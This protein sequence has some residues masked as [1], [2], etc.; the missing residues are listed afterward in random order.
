MADYAWLITRDHISIPGDDY[1]ATGTSGPRSITDE[2]LARLQAGE[3]K[4]F[5]LFDDDRILIYDGRIINEGNDEN[6]FAPLDDFGG[7]NEGCTII[8]YRDGHKWEVL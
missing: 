3:G 5:R 1:D 4:Q 7:P 6:L 8:K 2:Q